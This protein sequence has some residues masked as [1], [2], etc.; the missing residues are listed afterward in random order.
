MYTTAF[1][2]VL[3]AKGG[4]FSRGGRSGGKAAGRQRLQH[5]ISTN[6]DEDFEHDDVQNQLKN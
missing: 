1:K 2:H 3:G 5:K 4:A 6:R